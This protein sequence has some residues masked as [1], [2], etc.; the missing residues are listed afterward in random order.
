MGVLDL[1]RKKA[2][3]RKQEDPV[4]GSLTCKEPGWWE[5]R[6]TFGPT[7]TEVQVIVHTDGEAPTANQ[8]ELFR[9]LSNRYEQLRLGIGDVLLKLWEPWLNEIGDEDPLALPRSAPEMLERTQL[10]SVVV[11]GDNQLILSYGFTVEGIWDDASLNVR[12]D[13]WIPQEAGVDD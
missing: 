1:F 3:D 5:G 11:E 8:G 2:N 4:F 6:C 13:D 12:L 10:E 7:G 9:E